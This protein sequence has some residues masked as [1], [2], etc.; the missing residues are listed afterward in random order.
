MRTETEFPMEIT[1]KVIYRSGGVRESIEKCLSNK[2]LS[3]EITERPSGKGTFM[4]YTVSAV[5]SSE[6]LLHSVCSELRTLSGY[7]TMF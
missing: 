2:G 7:M 5:Y 1:F 3:H 4:S 6:D